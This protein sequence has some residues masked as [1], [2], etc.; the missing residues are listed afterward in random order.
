MQQERELIMV[1][2]SLVNP[3]GKLYPIKHQKGIIPKSGKL[4]TPL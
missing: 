2:K 4:D 1:L 3:H